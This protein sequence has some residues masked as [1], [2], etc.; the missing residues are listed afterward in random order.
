VVVDTD[1]WD[2]FRATMRSKGLEFTYSIE[3]SAEGGVEYHIHDYLDEAEDTLWA[4]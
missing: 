1:S 2:D 3:D 4:I